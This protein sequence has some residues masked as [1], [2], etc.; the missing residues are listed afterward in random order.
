MTLVE[1]NEKLLDSSLLSSDI[2]IDAV[3]KNH[4]MFM[5]Q[6]GKLDPHQLITILGEQMLF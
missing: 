6:G 4:E 3:N 5:E 1:L 2:S